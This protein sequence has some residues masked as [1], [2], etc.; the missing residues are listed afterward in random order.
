MSQHPSG[1][2]TRGARVCPTS[3]LGRMASVSGRRMVNTAPRPGSLSTS[4]LP[5]RL[6]IFDLTMSMPIPRP[7][8]SVTFSAVLRPGSQIIW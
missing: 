4:Q 5:L 8:I 3:R 2:G 1:G 6:S 7:E